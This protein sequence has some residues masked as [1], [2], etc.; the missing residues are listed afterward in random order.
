MKSDRENEEEEEE[1]CIMLINLMKVYI[2]L[3]SSYASWLLI[4]IV[5]KLFETFIFPFYLFFFTHSQTPKSPG[6]GNEFS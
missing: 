4:I 5:K 6:A 2:H 1:E 3:V